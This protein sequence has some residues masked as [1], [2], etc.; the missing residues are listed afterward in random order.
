[1][2][3]ASL[4]MGPFG[5]L[6]CQQNKDLHRKF[7][8]FLEICLGTDG[9]RQTL[10]RRSI[11]FRSPASRSTQNPVSLR[12]PFYPSSF[13]R[14]ILSPLSTPQSPEDW[15]RSQANPYASRRT[16]QRRIFII[17]RVDSGMLPHGPILEGPREPHD[18]FQLSHISE[19][20]ILLTHF[21]DFLESAHRL[22]YI[23]PYY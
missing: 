13:G 12:K 20:E 6:E 22:H 18:V 11:P 23:R 8:I 9:L 4:V 5:L 10:L 7:E 2:P 3:V 21:L 1:M 15:S 17:A 16:F 14:A 19:G